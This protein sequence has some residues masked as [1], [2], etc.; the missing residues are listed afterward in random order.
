MRSISPTNLAL[1]QARRLVA[2][3]FLWIV[4]RERDTNVPVPVGFWSD[5][6]NVSAEVLQSDTG[7][8]VTRDWYGSGT[9][10]AISGTDRRSASRTTGNSYSPAR[11]QVPRRTS[12][13]QSDDDCITKNRAATAAAAH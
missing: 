1:L 5:V 6:G 4:A 8:A 2:R 9:L 13:C 12:V 7:G 11:N 3:D 10:I